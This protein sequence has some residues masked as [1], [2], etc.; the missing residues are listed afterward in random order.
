MNYLGNPENLIKI[1]VQDKR[2]IIK[3]N[4]RYEKV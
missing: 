3:K 1:K 4:K 2:L